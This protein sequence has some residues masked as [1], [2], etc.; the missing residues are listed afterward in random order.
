MT[1]VVAKGV[2]GRGRALHGVR[3]KTHRWQ[4]Q[5]ERR[6]AVEREPSPVGEGVRRHEV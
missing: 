6:K 1:S 5:Q 4:G 3:P 2:H